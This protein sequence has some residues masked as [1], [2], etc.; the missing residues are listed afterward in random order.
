L[1]A[2]LVKIAVKPGKKEELLDFLV[3]DGEV[4]RDSEPG[5]R[6]F[7]FYTEAEGSDF[8]WLYEAYDDAEAFDFHKSHEPYQQF[9]STWRGTVIENIEIVMPLSESHWSLAA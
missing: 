8:V 5:T 9:T 1:I 7:E 6:R 3:W 2:L 4:A